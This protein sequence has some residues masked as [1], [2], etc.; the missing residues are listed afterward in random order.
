MVLMLAGNGQSLF[1]FNTLQKIITDNRPSARLARHK[2]KPGF[3][4]WDHEK[5]WP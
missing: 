1:F 5:A 3:I 4:D 2:N